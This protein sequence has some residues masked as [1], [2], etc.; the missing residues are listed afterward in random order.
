MEET[1]QVD[2]RIL[3]GLAMENGELL[4]VLIADTGEPPEYRGVRG[5]YKHA[6]DAL[7]SEWNVP[8]KDAAVYRYDP[9]LQQWEKAA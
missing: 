2:K 5:Y 7:A 3:A 8:G 9:V 4:H 6:A 1:I